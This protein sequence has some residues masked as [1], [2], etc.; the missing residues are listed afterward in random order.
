MGKG[1]K[2]RQQ[3]QQQEMVAW[4]T[5]QKNKQLQ[6]STRKVL[7]HLWGNVW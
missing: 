4:G 7:C 2:A 3:K 1:N 6:Q 5:K